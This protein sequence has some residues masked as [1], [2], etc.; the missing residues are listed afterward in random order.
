MLR[1]ISSRTR[2]GCATCTRARTLERD[3]EGRGTRVEY[4]AAALGKSIH[5][6]LEYDYRGRAR[7]RSRGSSSRAT[8][9]AGSTVRTASSPRCP[10]STR[11]HYDLAV[12]LAVP[13]PG[14]LK[15]RAAGLIM[16]SALKELKKPG[17]S[18]RL[19]DSPCGRRTPALVSRTV[20]RHQPRGLNGSSEDRP[21]RARMARQNGTAADDVH[22]S[23]CRHSM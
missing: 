18:G 10:A 23:G 2:N 8:C 5:Y 20:T 1:S 11:V 13:L 7:S 15:R 17:R 6:V 12:E 22:P 4:R 9:C 3:A 19:N 21:D 14:L 16:G